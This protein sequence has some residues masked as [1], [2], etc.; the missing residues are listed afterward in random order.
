MRNGHDQVVREFCSEEKMMGDEKRVSKTYEMLKNG[1]FNN[2]ML[3]F[4]RTNVP[5][6]KKI[7]DKVM[8]TSQTFLEK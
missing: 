8:G 5:K 1:C 2:K 3:A 6:G 7:K 4:S